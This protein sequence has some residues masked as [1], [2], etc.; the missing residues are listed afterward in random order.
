MSSNRRKPEHWQV[1]RHINV[2]VIIALMVQTLAFAWYAGQLTQRVA[3]VEHKVEN[4]T[5]QG[6]RLTRLEEQ[7]KGVNDKLVDIRDVLRT[8][9]S[10]SPPSAK[11]LSASR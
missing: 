2:S 1:D 8:F 11:R 10:L 3:D 5:P 4:V 9:T 6:D 7:F